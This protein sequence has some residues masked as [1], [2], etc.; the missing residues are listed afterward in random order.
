MQHDVSIIG[1]GLAG[2]ALSIQL[3]AQGWKVVLLEKETYPFH[4]VCG[5][6][7]SME[8][9]DFLC[10]LSVPLP[11][12]QLPML[13]R[14][15]VTAP[16]G[17]VLETALPLGGFGISRYKLDAA[18]AAIARSKGVLVYEGA[19]VESLQQEAGMFRLGVRTADGP[20]TV[21]S[22]VCC[23]AWGKRSNLDIQ[24]QRP[25]VTDKDNRI[26][27]WV[28]IKYH[29]RTQWPA[30]LIGLHN[31]HDGYCG[32]SRI[33]DGWNCLCYLT[34]AS[35]LKGLQVAQ[36][37]ATLMSR[38]Y[39]L[40][41]I[42]ENSDRKPGFPIAIS[43]VSFQSKQQV[44]QGVLLLGDAAGMIT[45]LCG[46]GM[47]MALH[48]SKLAASEV[49]LFLSGSQTRYGMECAYAQKWKTLFQSRL[50]TGRLLQRFFGSEKGSSTMVSLM[51]RV[52]FLT[53]ALIKKTHGRPF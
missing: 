24:W 4:R 16:G 48:A 29:L 23:G 43:Q 40:R 5:E 17:K 22:K 36:L 27:N 15:Q 31:F 45:P 14:L 44:E 30:D 13:R 10:G 38:N 11:E 34:R 52:P 35:N 7:I 41:H 32:I 46:N 9:W 3:A 19:K 42:L 39:H 12:W 51:G 18:L 20:L 53:R 6:Y 8:A 2:L 49:G 47:S 50:R 26:S 1:G 37:E 21:T 25:F 28:G 33:E